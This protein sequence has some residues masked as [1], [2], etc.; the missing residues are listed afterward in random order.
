MLIHED[1]K[2]VRALTETADFI[3]SGFQ[4]FKEQARLPNALLTEA[5]FYAGAALALKAR[6]HFERAAETYGPQ[7]VAFL[8]GLI[9]Q[10]IND[11][12]EKHAMQLEWE[13]HVPRSWK[14]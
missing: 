8:N 3:D 11:W 5:A 7:C 14:Q 13:P 6:E 2:N 10:E 1:Q 12:M 4:S 9:A